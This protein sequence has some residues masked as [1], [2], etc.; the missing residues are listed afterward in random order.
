MRVLIVAPLSRNNI[1]GLKPLADSAEYQ[2]YFA[3]TYTF[4][5]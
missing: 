3:A 4:Q 1:L 2:S 5:Q